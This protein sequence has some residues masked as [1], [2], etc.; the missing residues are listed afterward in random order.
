ML[1]T[2]TLAP[3][4]STA[5]ATS[6]ARSLRSRI[7]FATFL[8]VVMNNL[9]V[10]NLIYVPLA[11][12]VA[13]DATATM[14]RVAESPMTYRSG[15]L[16][17][18]FSGILFLV[19]ACLLHDLFKDVDRKQAM[20][21]V[22][23]VSGAV[24]IGLA[25]LIPQIGVLVVSS[26]AEYLTVFTRPQL[27]AAGL[28]LINL[29]SA[30]DILAMAFWGVW[31]FPFGV[32]IIKSRF[33]PRVLGVFLIVAGAA[34]LA[35]SFISI[36]FPAHRQMTFYLAMPF[37]AGEMVAVLWLLIKGAVIPPAE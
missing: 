1:M 19:V 32:L 10:F 11:F 36:L 27:D 37:M 35:T 29:V 20:L 14:R 26:K 4:F 9:G 25:N 13:G 12:R 5:P 24:A 2:T 7:R 33:I 23:S 17:G 8:Y 30:G 31:L 18:L 6:D 16:C 22:V 34:Y 21:L 28:A 3:P 15:I